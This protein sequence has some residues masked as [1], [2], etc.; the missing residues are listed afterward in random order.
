[1]RRDA[2]TS[3]ESLKQEIRSVYASDREGAEDLIESYLEQ[4]LVEATPEERLDLVE[5]LLS[6]F[7][8]KPA[9]ARPAKNTEQMEISRLFSVL[10]G[11][12][13]SMEELFSMEVLDKLADSVNTIFDTLNRIIG[14]I[15]GTLLGERAELETI[16]HIIGSSIEVG[17]ETDSL[18]IYLDQIQK[19]FLV[20]HEAF[21][22][23]A[24]VKVGQVIAELDP[25]AIAAGAGGGLKF[26]PLRKAELFEI[27][28]VKFKEVKGW[29]E[30]GRFANE[31]VREFEKTCKKLYK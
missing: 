17:G 1:M 21:K 11:K 26:G 5:G 4:R 20:A 15:H 13:V 2:P 29:F 22:Q 12:S 23:A 19:A 16:R 3:L 24:K 8:S 25:E 31:L 10:L 6:Q 30:S 28:K 27:Y 7:P 14:V 9:A 18:Q